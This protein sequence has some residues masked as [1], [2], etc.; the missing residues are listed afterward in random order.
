MQ[1][2]IR[3]N[4]TLIFEFNYTDTIA[5]VKDI[6]YQKTGIPSK[7]IVLNYNG[8]LLKDTEPISKHI[9]DTDV[10]IHM[11]IKMSV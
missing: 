10:T 11:N 2:F 3:N 4:T 5:Y 7:H 8:K 1:V 9:I 6:Y